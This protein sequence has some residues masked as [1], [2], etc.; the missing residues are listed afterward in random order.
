[1]S[2]IKSRLW[3]RNKSMKSALISVLKNGGNVLCPQNK[4]MQ[5]LRNSNI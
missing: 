3:I 1:M 2:L 5:R 4:W